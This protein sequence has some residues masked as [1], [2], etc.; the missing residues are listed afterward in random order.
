MRISFPKEGKI[1][2][3]GK[4]FDYKNS[5]VFIFIDRHINNSSFTKYDNNLVILNSQKTYM[6]NVELLN[7]KQLNQFI[8]NL[9]F[10]KKIE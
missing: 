7:K 8:E 4:V 10:Q 1:K 9:I 5:N 6:V 3:D 2:I